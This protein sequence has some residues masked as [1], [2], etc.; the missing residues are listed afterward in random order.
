MK[1]LFLVHQIGTSNSRERVQIWRL[2]KKA[3]ALLYRNSVYVLPYSRERLEDFQWLAQQIV[4][5]EGSASVF[6][7]EAQKDGEDEELKGLFLQRSAEEYRALVQQGGELLRRLKEVQGGPRGATLMKKLTQ[8]EAELGRSLQAARQADFFRHP[9]GSKAEALLESIHTK[10]GKLTAQP[11]LS[12]TVGVRS[13]KEYQ[14][15]TW[16]TREHIHIDRVASAWLIRRW[17][18]PKAEFLFAPE[19]AM[20]EDAVPFDVYGAEFS[21][22]GDD[23]TF[24]TL[25]KAFNLDDE[26]LHSLAQIVHDIDLKDGKFGR[27][28]AAGLDLVIR[29][30]AAGSSSDHEVL[31][32]G[33]VIFDGLYAHLSGKKPSTQQRKKKG[34]NTTRPRPV[35]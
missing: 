3:G 34:R 10:L 11:E 12:V 21:H 18:A 29:A 25:L 19:G 15:R 9:L 1:W 23:C 13:R 30:L 4:D 27:P 20:P 16:A 32:K 22:H 24:E 26:V 6:A 14:H 17:I 33:T 28:E 2:T 8:R 5:L 31:E 7:S 35:S